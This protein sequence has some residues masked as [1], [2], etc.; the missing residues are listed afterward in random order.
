MSPSRNWVQRIVPLALIVLAACGGEARDGVDAQ[1]TTRGSFEVT[2]E[3]L[4]IPEKVE[5]LAKY[6]YDFA[7]VMKYRVLA[8][9]HG[10]LDSEVIYVGHYNPLKPRAEAADGR[11]DDIGGDLDQFRV[12]DRH[13]L[14]MEVPIEDYCMAG[15]INK[16]FDQETGPVYWAVWTNR[17]VK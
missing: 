12:G 7:L 5:I 15:I 1:V 6:T 17:V 14:A 9:H 8:V 2:A 16:Y 4:E 3:L 13:R 10:E 11:I